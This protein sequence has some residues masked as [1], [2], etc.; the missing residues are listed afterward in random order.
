M[1][2]I[3]TSST[4]GVMLLFNNEQY[5]KYVVE[6]LWTLRMI[7]LRKIEHS[8]C[9]GLYW[10]T[11]HPD[12]WIAEVTNEIIGRVMIRGYHYE[13]NGEPHWCITEPRGGASDFLTYDEA[14]FIA[15]VVGNE[16]LMDELYRLRESV[17]FCAD[18]VNN[19]AFHIYKVTNDLIG[20][21]VGNRLSCV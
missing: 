2:T 12:F 6:V 15:G 4:L 18:D 10:D 17:S 1:K 19:P 9:K 8:D 3:D 7:A 11:R 21:L 13:T 5:Y 14:N 16:T 20:A